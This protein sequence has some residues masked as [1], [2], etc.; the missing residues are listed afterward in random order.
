MI[1]FRLVVELDAV[2]FTSQH[3]VLFRNEA[4]SFGKFSCVNHRLIETIDFVEQSRENTFA[5][6]V[7]FQR[8]L[9]LFER[10][11]MSFI[12]SRDTFSFLCERNVFR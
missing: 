2:C 9:R 8:R 6:L 7:E 11:R 1:E 4:I 5:A 12:T 3:A 10:E